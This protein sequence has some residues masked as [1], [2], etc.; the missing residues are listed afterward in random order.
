MALDRCGNQPLQQL[1]KKATPPELTSLVQELRGFTAELAR[2]SWS[3]YVI[4]EVVRRLHATPGCAFIIDEIAAEAVELAR[5]A[6]GNYSVNCSLELYH[7]VVTG[8]VTVDDATLNGIK[9]MIARLRAADKL[10]EHPLGLH[11]YRKAGGTR[12][13]ATQPPHN[14][15]PAYNAPGGTVPPPPPGPDAGYHHPQQHH[16]PAELPAPREAPPPLV[17]PHTPMIVTAIV[18]AAYPNL[19]PLGSVVDQWLALGAADDALRT[20]AYRAAVADGLLIEHDLGGARYAQLG[21]RGLG[22]FIGV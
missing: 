18:A 16:Y 13:V 10:A 21:P 17:G 3:N 2:G 6:H 22:L 20:D 4:Q 14:A 19:A 12:P 7:R 11:L 1:L 8:D 5:H 9:H 15:P